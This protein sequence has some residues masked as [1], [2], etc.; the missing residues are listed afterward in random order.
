MTT[1]T[2][3][4]DIDDSQ[5]PAWMLSEHTGLASQEQDAEDAEAEWDV[6]CD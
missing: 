1:P 5:T 3:T 4:P 6:D 2:Q